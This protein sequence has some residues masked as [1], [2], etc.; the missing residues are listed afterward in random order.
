[1]ADSGVFLERSFLDNPLHTTTTSHLLL[2][3]VVVS[4]LKSTAFFLHVVAER[5]KGRK[6]LTTSHMAPAECQY[7]DLQIGPPRGGGK[8][9]ATK[10]GAEGCYKVSTEES[11]IHEETHKR[12]LK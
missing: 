7:P 12:G 2:V 6:P 8:K 1:M 3:C 10:W 5:A 9:G 4:T 11:K